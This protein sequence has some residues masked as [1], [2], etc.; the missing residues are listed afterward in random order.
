MLS[1][2]RESVWGSKM[3]WSREERYTRLEDVSEAYIS[4]LT[5]KVSAGPYRQK[6]HIQPKTG[7]LNDPNGFSYYNRQ[8]HLFYQWFPLGPVHGVKYWYHVASDNLVDWQDLGIAMAPDTEYD[9]HGVFSGTGFVENDQLHLFYT[10]NTR[11]EDWTRIP[12]QCHAVMGSDNQIKKDAEPLI[13][14]SPI[15]YTDNFRDPKVIEQVG[16]Y[17]CIIGAETSDHQGAIAYYVSEDLKDWTYQQ[18]IALK[19][20]IASENQGFMW[21]CPDYFELADQGVLLFSPQG[22][23]PEGDAYHNIYQS[24]Y[25]VGEPLD[26][27]TG[28]FQVTEAFNEL[29]RGF[30]FYAPQ[31]MTD[32]QGRQLLV[33]WLGLPGVDC[34]TDAFGWA[35]CLTI[36]RELS[37]QNGQLY[38]RPVPE[39]AALRGKAVVK[40]MKLENEALLVKEFSARTYE[41]KATFKDI[42][43]TRVGLAFRKGAEEATSFYYDLAAKKLVFDRSQSGKSVTDAYGTVRRCDFSEEALE[44]RLFMDESSVEIF[45]NDGLEVFTARIYSQADHNHVQFFADGQAS[46]TATQW[47]I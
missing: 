13:S 15:G 36:P 17:Y 28:E 47:E 22:M 18:A 6:F 5:K 2:I 26:F 45:V 10:G 35:H 46:V 37:L 1:K 9:S 44:I 40:E 14:D 34:V 19:G 4:E 27:A 41:L 39:L 11:T 32:P 31:T 12:Y 43:G 20:N 8:Y 24:G 25:L 7:L 33:G 23:E 3:E 16:R 38:Q 42:K 29:D 30:D 21:E